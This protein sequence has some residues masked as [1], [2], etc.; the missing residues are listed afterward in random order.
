M[1]FIYGGISI[2]FIFTKK[3]NSRNKKTPRVIMPA[4]ASGWTF[5]AI[6]CTKFDFP[7]YAAG[8]NNQ[9]TRL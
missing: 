5:S 4:A 2:F 7:A 8:Q 9:G 1:L 6:S 3:L